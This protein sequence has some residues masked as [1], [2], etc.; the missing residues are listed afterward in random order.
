MS[1]ICFD[2]LKL[3]Q[4]NIYKKFTYLTVY[5]FKL[6]FHSFS[7]K[8]FS[9]YLRFLQGACHTQK[10]APIVLMLMCV[11]EFI[12]YFCILFFFIL[13]SFCPPIKL[14][15]HNNIEN[16]TNGNST[17][18]VMTNKK[19]SRVFCCYILQVKRIYIKYNRYY[20]YLC[21]TVRVEQS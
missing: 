15:P 8:S 12:F 6:I 13:T 11:H 17:T 7:L 21:N 2:G 3:F 1:G 18:N 14:L 5:K 20:M 4:L 10:H 16:V 9:L 19:K